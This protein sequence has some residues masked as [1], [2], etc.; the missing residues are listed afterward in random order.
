MGGSKTIKTNIRVLATSNRNLLKE[1][2][3]GKFRQDLYYRLSVFPV[4]VPPLRERGDDILLL[5]ETFLR[6]FAKVHGV[7]PGGWS[8]EALTAM[9]T[10]PWRGNVREL[11]NTVERAVI[12]AESGRPIPLSLLGLPVILSARDVEPWPLLIA[13]A[14]ADPP[15]PLVAESANSLP[16]DYGTATRESDTPRAR[17][18]LKSLEEFERVHIF[19]TLQHT[20]GS[21]GKAAEIL[22]ITDRTLRNKLAL[23]RGQ[24]IEIPTLASDEGP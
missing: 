7:K 18:S 8:S 12:L 16:A 3:E 5:A 1:A 9:R 4:H 23:Y 15:G 21:R 10:Y 20:S 13:E 14:N 22:G 19:E 6:R 24:G 11:Q 17:P 2:E